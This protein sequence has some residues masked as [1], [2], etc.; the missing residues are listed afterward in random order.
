MKEKILYIFPDNSTFIQKDIALLS[1]NYVVVTPGHN[2]SNKGH[3]PL[4]FLKQ[5]LFLLRNLAGTRAIFV[6]FGGY[7]SLLPALAGK[8]TRTPVYIIPG[9]TD[10]VSFPSLNYGSL[11]KPLMR[12]FIRWSFQL[13][14]EL[15][16]V[17][18]SLILADYT[19]LPKPDYPKQGI[20]YFFPGLKTPW[21]V[22][23]NGFDPEFFKVDPELSKDN[24][25]IAVA[26][27]SNMMRV[28]V[29]GVD[30]VID[31][32]KRFGNCSF[33]I[34]GLSGNVAE[35][36]TPLPPN[37]VLYPFLPKEKFISLLAES[38]FI[39]QLSVSEGFPNALCEAMLCHCVP[40]GSA[41]GAIPEIIG[42]SG[43]IATSPEKDYLYDK[44]DEILGLSPETLRQ[45][46]F[47]ARQRIAERYH[48]SK[49]KKA[50]LELISER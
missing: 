18:H 22:I 49:R 16:P 46:A 6:M 35:Q 11:R 21:R 8:I 33:T 36:L 43:F 45:L 5:F 28:R 9:G 27:V 44:V 15:L 50:F 30:L 39:L 20:K 38:R 19:Y 26:P 12:T 37:L 47:R 24:S 3:T 41:V 32:A 48:I 2:W 31:L 34:V 25:F 7:W 13:C 10:C 14:T 40:L 1:D 4:N 42:D 29:K 23:H 17:D